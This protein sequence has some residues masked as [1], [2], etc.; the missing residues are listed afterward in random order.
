MNTYRL[1]RAVHRPI[2]SVY[3]RLSFELT[4]LIKAATPEDAIAQ[5][6]RLGYSSPVVEPS[7]EQIQ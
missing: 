6:K 4:R 2:D 7:K 3:Y 1:L 5:A